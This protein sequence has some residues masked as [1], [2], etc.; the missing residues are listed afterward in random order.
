MLADLRSGLRHIA[1]KPFSA[2]TMILVMA[3]GIG[4]GSAI[5]LLI[6]SFVN[7]PVPGLARDES[8]VRIRGVDRSRGPERTI[9]REFSY[10]EYREYAARQDL[11]AAVSAWTSSDVVLDVG[12]TE[13]RLLSGAA[14][15]VTAKYFQVLGAQ[16]V[17]GAGVP[18]DAADEAGSP[19]LAG[20]ISH[21]LW[22]RHF[23]RARDVVGRTL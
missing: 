17:L 3:L 2:G 9:G 12:A 4:C 7:S 8:A 16:P 19:Q 21:V 23:D 13:E 22:D 11:F 18:T 14:T 10:Q 5:F 6:Y 15:Y 20:V 1:R